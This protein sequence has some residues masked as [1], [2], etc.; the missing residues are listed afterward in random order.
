MD[1]NCDDPAYSSASQ[2]RLSP[3]QDATQGVV[4]LVRTGADLWVCFGNLQQS[5]GGGLAKLF[6]DTKTA[7]GLLSVAIAP[8]GSLTT[9]A[10]AS[11]IA[12][13]VSDTVATWS[14]EL[15][16]PA[17]AV[18]GWDHVVS[19]STEHLETFT[20]PSNVVES[21]RWPYASDV[22]QSSTWA[23]TLLGNWKSRIA[24]PFVER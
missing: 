2:L 11:G 23:L 8:D 19:L 10:K 16:I 5:N 14:A 13:N 24:L 22:S 18:G 7:D 21:H 1:G 20:S 9:N 3:Y 4:R 17:V 6:V 15:R 12:D